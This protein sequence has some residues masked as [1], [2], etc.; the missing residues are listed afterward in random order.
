MMAYLL[1]HKDTHY[2]ETRA[3]ISRIVHLVVKTGI[4]T[5]LAAVLV[6]ILYVALPQR[7]YYAAVGAILAKLYSNALLVLFNSRIHIRGARREAPTEPSPF[8]ADTHPG[9]THRPAA[10]SYTTRRGT[11]RNWSIRLHGSTARSPS[12]AAVALSADRSGAE[13]AMSSFGGVHVHEQVWVHTDDLEMKERA[14]ETEKTV[15]LETDC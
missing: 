12:R 11:R 9:S 7:A 6:L 15:V 10:S 8:A 1:T 13:S 3:L 5:A 14:V 2:P 4:L